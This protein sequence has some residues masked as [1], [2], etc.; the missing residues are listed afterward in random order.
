[1][2]IN[3]AVPD[4]LDLASSMTRDNICVPIPPGGSY[5]NGAERARRLKSLRLEPADI[6]REEEIGYIAIR[7]VTSAWRPQSS[8]E[9]NEE[10]EKPVTWAPLSRK[11]T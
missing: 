3:Y 8:Q 2:L 9:G 11:R 5:L 10:D 4:I 6:R 7:A 1:M